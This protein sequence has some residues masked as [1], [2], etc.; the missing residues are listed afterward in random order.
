MLE[1]LDR[2]LAGEV[3]WAPPAGGLGCWLALP[4]GV[5]PGRL[6]AEARRRGV[7]LTPGETFYTDPRRVAAHGHVGLSFASEPPERIRQGVAL[8]AEALRAVRGGATAAGA[9]S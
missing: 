7:Q 1:A 9:S 4:R 3:D 6:R 2:D 5:D 8:F